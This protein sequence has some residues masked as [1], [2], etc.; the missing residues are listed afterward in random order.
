MVE[1]KEKKPSLSMIG[2]TRI[3]VVVLEKEKKKKKSKHV[4]KFN[5]VVGES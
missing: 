1:W 4:P 3:R 5:I 2:F